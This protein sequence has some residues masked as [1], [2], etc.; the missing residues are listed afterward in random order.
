M[1]TKSTTRNGRAMRQGSEDIMFV[2]SAIANS[3]PT[4]LADLSEECNRLIVQFFRL[5]LLDL[6]TTPFSESPIEHENR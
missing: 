2:S 5:S 3:L 6:E 4:N 1:N